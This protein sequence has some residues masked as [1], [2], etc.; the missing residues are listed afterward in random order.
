MGKSYAVYCALQPEL[1]AM[2]QAI[3]CLLR[4]TRD[5]ARA[6][7]LPL[8]GYIT[9][10]SFELPGFYSYDLNCDRLHSHITIL[11]ICALKLLGVDDVGSFG[12]R[13]KNFG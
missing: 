1:G 3:L 9:T 7:F 2:A 13:R 5:L 10:K 8:R 12:K 6:P 4:E 11:P